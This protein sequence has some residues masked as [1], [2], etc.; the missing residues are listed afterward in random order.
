MVDTAPRTALSPVE[1]P[2]TVEGGRR[3]RKKLATRQALR[4]A[5]LELVAER[6]LADVTVEDIA[7]AA[8]VATRT[9]FNY[10]PSKEAAVIGL[11]P[12]RVVRMSAQVLSRPPEETPLQAVRA[13][14][15][16]HAEAIEAEIDDLGEGRG[17]W[18]RRL[19]AVRADPELLRAFSANVTAVER[20]LTEA[21]ALRLGRDL[22]HDPYPALVS[23]SALSAARVAG[24]YWSA[25][26]GAESL[27]ALTAAAIDAIGA[28]LPDVPTPPGAPRPGAAGRPT[29][30]PTSSRRNDAE[31]EDD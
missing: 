21:L 6:G 9:F 26:D 4:I 7:E 10:F 16:E 29:G 22:A 24:L 30:R 27:G 31:D 25:N 15:V 14:L 12:D 13:A 11:D 2:S 20:G 8:D 28:G 1:A 23:A 19:C 3:E 17:P 18:L 5:A